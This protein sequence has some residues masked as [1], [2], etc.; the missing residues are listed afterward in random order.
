MEFDKNGKIVVPENTYLEEDNAVFKC[1][2]NDAGWKGICSKNA[3]EYNVSKKRKWCCD[4]T[5]CCQEMIENNEKGFPCMESKLFV[6]FQIDP[7][8]YLSEDRKHEHKHIK[9]INKGKIAFLTTISPE[10]PEKERYFIGLFDIERV[11]NERYIFGNKETSIVIPP[12]IKLK[13]WN[14]FK[15]MDESKKWSSGLFRYI[16]DV[17]ALQILIDLKKEFDKFSGFNKEKDNLNMLI[18]RYEGYLRR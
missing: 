18:K 9:G 8:D 7:G 1:N 14:Y 12:E 5:N 17:Q 10:M 15:N 13:F 4:R 11:E 6:N 2:W 3:R 16:N